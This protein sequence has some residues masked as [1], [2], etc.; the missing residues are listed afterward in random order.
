MRVYMRVA[1]L[2]CMALFLV[3]GAAVAIQPPD[4]NRTVTINGAAEVAAFIESP[5]AG[6]FVAAGAAKDSPAI[7]FVAEN[8]TVTGNMTVAVDN[9]SVIRYIQ[10]EGDA[11]LV[12]SDTHD[13]AG[14]TPDGE[15]L[16]TW[17]VPLGEVSSVDAVP[18]GGIIAAAN[19][20]HPTL[21]RLDA[22]GTPLWNKTYADTS[23]AGLG[24][25]QSVKAVEGGYIV[26][27]YAT[28]VIASGDAVGLVMY[29]SEDGTVVWEE[30]F[31][32][33]GIG[34]VVNISPLP[35]GGYIAPALTTEDEAAVLILNETGAADQLFFYPKRME[36]IYYADAAP[37]G[38]YYLVGYDAS[39]VNGEPQYL[40]M[41]VS[42]DGE[43]EWMQWFGD[44][45]I[46]A[47]VPLGDGFVTGGENGEISFF[48]FHKAGKETDLSNAWM[49]IFVILAGIIAGYL[50]YRQH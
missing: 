5:A 13:F 47:F 15:I 26:A 10:E 37:G 25:I 7:W 42:P 34:Y 31:G 11:Y 16:W 46:R 3:C 29:L 49:F 19:Y 36:L 6:G 18:E 43:E 9:A 38:G 40:V 28:P 33:E 8:G 39:L 41:G 23:G 22:D 20:L 4:L 14:V 24:R 21:Y 50:I 1:L 32:E 45:G 48:T 30:R 17:H 27:G 44:T 35:G 12:F 2:V